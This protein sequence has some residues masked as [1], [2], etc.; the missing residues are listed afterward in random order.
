M[1]FEYYKKI[2]CLP[3][4]STEKGVLRTLAFHA[5]PDNNNFCCPSWDTIHSESG[6]SRDSI[7]TSLKVAELI[8]LIESKKRGN[9]ETGKESSEY[10]FH[11]TDINFYKNKGKLR[12]SEDTKKEVK[13]KLVEARKTVKDDNLLKGKKAKSAFTNN[14]KS[15]CRTDLI[16]PDTCTHGKS[17]KSDSGLSYLHGFEG[18]S[19]SP[20]TRLIS[21]DSGLEVIDTKML[22]T[23][24]TTKENLT[25]SPCNEK[26][27]VLHETENNSFEVINQDSTIDKPSRQKDLSSQS[28]EQWLADYE[29]TN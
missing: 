24:N 6:V 19:I 29:H 20:D 16:S 23:T 4:K 28:N 9:I 13:R 11:F 14:D 21:P 1:N 17:Q 10:F 5:N 8:G 3:M 22:P 15:I 7:G 2:L 25:N 12:I 26:K 18:Y 27:T